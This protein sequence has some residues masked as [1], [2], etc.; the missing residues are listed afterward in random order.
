MLNDYYFYIYIYIFIFSWHFG[1]IKSHGVFVEDMP[2]LGVAVRVWNILRLPPA[3]RPHLH[4]HE[5]HPVREC[6]PPAVITRLTN[7]HKKG[8][9][10]SN[11]WLW[12]WWCRERRRRKRRVRLDSDLDQASTCFPV[13]LSRHQ[14]ISKSHTYELYWSALTCYALWG[15]SDS[16]SLPLPP[17]LPPSFSAWF[18][19][20]TAFFS[21]KVSRVLPTFFSFPLE[22][23][24]SHIH[25][26]SQRPQL[27]F[28]KHIQPDL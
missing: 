27:G 11:P 5:R 13:N 28:S 1:E 22:L 16:L 6:V 7:K 26:Q 4:R 25:A 20:A 17:S 14:T 18:I 24:V 21:K 12:G 15:A 3:P 2:S 19:N 8:K 23:N 10:M 9:M